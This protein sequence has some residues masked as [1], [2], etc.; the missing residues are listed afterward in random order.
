MAQ[1]GQQRTDST[2]TPYDAPYNKNERI[3]AQYTSSFKFSEISVG[4]HHGCKPNSVPGAFDMGA[5]ISI[6]RVSLF[7]KQ[8]TSLAAY[9]TR[10]Y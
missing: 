10:N 1:N 2:Q 3:G 7:V 9:R 8:L 6:A 5:L 4:R